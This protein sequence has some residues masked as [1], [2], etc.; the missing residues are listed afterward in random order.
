MASRKN[1][2]K[3]ITPAHADTFASC[4]DH[5]GCLTVLGGV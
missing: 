2:R 1:L 4:G 3:M 5:A